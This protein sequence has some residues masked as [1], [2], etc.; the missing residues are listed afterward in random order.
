[1]NFRKSDG[2]AF[3]ASLRPAGDQCGLRCCQRMPTEPGG[4]MFPSEDIPENP[5]GP[6]SSEAEARKLAVELA[7]VYGYS[8]NQIEWSYA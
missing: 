6:L 2:A 7:R 3:H 5:P 8:A 1:M 4:L